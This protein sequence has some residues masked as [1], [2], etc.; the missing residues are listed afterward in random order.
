MVLILE[1]IL[2]SFHLN[3][4]LCLGRAMQQLTCLGVAGMWQIHCWIVLEALYFNVLELLF[5]LFSWTFCL[6][7]EL[8]QVAS[9]KI[10][11]WFWK[12]L[13]SPQFILI[14]IYKVSVT[15]N[16]LWRCTSDVQSVIPSVQQSRVLLWKQNFL[17]LLPPHSPPLPPAFP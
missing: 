10:S 11:W 4:S 14:S 15:W 2:F 12:E 9:F 1:V 8:Q 7:L 16:I 3:M 13:T 17:F 5:K 6:L